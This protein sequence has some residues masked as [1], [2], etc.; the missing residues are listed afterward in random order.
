[1]CFSLSALRF[2]PE[3]QHSD[4]SNGD[5]YQH[6]GDCDVHLKVGVRDH[7]VDGRA[8]FFCGWSF[9]NGESG[10][11]EGAAVGFGA[12]E[13]GDHGVFAW[14]VWLPHVAERAADV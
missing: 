7:C 10:F 5:Y 12:F 6:R 2:L 1:L 13:R 11:C 3:Q 14:D 9:C 8:W 4:D